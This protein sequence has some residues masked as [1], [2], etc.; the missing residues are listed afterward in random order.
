V[1]LETRIW[2]AL[3]VLAILIAPLVAVYAAFNLPNSFTQK[4][5][6]SSRPISS[7]ITSALSA[8]GEKIKLSIIV[9]KIPVTNLI[10]SNTKLVNTGSVAIIPSDY[11]DHLSINVEKQ[12][13]L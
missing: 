10:L 1:L 9:D 3:N 4:Q 7:D 8:L 11:Y 12:W 5:L 6:Q 2:Q 13:K